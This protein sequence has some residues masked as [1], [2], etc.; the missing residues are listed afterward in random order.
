MSVSSRDISRNVSKLSERNL[1]KVSKSNSQLATLRRSIENGPSEYEYKMETWFPA[2]ELDAK[3]SDYRRMT[4]RERDLY[5]PLL[6]AEFRRQDL[7]DDKVDLEREQLEKEESYWRSRRGDT[8]EIA[9]HEPS[10]RDIQLR[11]DLERHMVSGGCCP[12]NSAYR[13]VLRCGP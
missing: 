12:P 4:T 11:A 6:W 13:D 10:E 2:P 5:G 9:K 7:L 8:S 3:M 1:S